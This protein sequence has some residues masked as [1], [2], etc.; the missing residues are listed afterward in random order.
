MACGTSLPIAF[1]TCA[2]AASMSRLPCGRPPLTSTSAGAPNA[3]ASSIARRLSSYQ[4][5]ALKNP[6]LH[7][8][9]TASPASRTT[10]AA[11]VAEE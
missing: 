2:R 7:S 4:P 11:S 6:P 9:V 10:A 3:A 5:S 8:E 1:P